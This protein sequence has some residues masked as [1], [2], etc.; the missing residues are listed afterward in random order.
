MHGRLN[1]VW[2][3]RGELS[4]MMD[5]KRTVGSTSVGKS[6]SKIQR[7]SVP[8]AV[9]FAS[10]FT[11]YRPTEGRTKL[12]RETIRGSSRRGPGQFFA[13]MVA[14]R[15]ALTE[16]MRRHGRPVSLERD[17]IRLR[18]FPFFGPSAESVAGN[19]TRR[20]HLPICHFPTIHRVLKATGW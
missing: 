7:L 12:E 17:F 9:H 20:I 1:T 5:I 15:N 13:D 3:D 6:S 18:Q 4:P 11:S 14:P 2:I 16:K 10:T 19:A 8:A